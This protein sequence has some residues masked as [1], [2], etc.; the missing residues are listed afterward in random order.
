LKNLNDV[1]E[2]KRNR[3]SRLSYAS[4]VPVLFMLGGTCT[5]G[6]LVTE[7]LGVRCSACAGSM[8]GGQT[9]GQMGLS[10]DILISHTQRGRE[11]FSQTLTHMHTHICCPHC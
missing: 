7:S 11:T 9:P 2:V 3:T 8:T 10:Q 1:E 6:V 5:L 4:A